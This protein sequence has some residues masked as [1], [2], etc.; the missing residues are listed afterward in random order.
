[1]AGLIGRVVRATMLEILTMDYLRTARAKGLREFVVVARHGL[2]NALLPIITVVGQ[3]Y[4]SL[5]TGAVLIEWIFAWPGI[6]R[7]MF[8]ASVSQDFPAIMGVSLTIAAMYLLLN[9]LVD[10]AYYHLDPRVRA[11]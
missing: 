8:R 10:L 4:G 3:C 5:L 1:V 2:R 7:Y 11:A 6:G 9:L